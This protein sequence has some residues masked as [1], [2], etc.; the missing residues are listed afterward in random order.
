MKIY[1]WFFVLLTLAQTTFTIVWFLLIKKFDRV[2]I[3][4]S[5]IYAGCMIIG[6][7]AYE[8]EKYRKRKKDLINNLP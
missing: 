7:I 2:V 4:S 3:L 1:K 5:A 6:Y 8:I